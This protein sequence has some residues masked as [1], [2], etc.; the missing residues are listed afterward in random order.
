MDEQGGER[1]VWT[2]QNPLLK[3]AGARA[4][5]VNLVNAWSGK[6]VIDHGDDEGTLYDH[7]THGGVPLPILMCENK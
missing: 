4:V 7:A 6:G 5:H 1:Q 3:V 2:R